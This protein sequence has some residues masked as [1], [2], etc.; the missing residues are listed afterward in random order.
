M[1]DLPTK[2]TNELI[3][4]KIKKKMN[5]QAKQNQPQL[6]NHLNQSYLILT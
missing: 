2:E 6:Q 3:E 4:K 5:Q 1:N